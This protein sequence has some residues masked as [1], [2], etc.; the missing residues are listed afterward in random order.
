MN[1]GWVYNKKDKSIFKGE[2]GMQGNS[3]GFFGGGG[4]DE[5]TDPS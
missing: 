4:Q 3:G 1:I 5:R 2:L